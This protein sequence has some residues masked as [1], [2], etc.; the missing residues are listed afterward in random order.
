MEN[1]IQ[2]LYEKVVSVL[3]ESTTWPAW[4]IWANLGFYALLILGFTG[5]KIK[6]L[7]SRD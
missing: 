6:R 2:V 1:I 7:F 3:A 5:R 4:A